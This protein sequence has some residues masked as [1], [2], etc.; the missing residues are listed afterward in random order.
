MFVTD[1]HGGRLIVLSLDDDLKVVA[2]HKV[3]L[4]W[5]VAV[6]LGESVLAIGHMGIGCMDMRAASPKDW[7][8]GAGHPSG[9]VADLVY[10]GDRLF[11]VDC[12]KQCL[13][14]FAVALSAAAA[15]GPITTAGAAL[16][17]LTPI[18]TVDS[19]SVGAVCLYGV[20]AAPDGVSVFVGDRS[21]S[22]APLQIDG[23]G[24][25][26]RRLPTATAVGKIWSLC[27]AHNKLFVLTESG[28][29]AL[30]TAMDLQT[31]TLIGPVATAAAD[32]PTAIFAAEDC[33]IFVETEHTIT[34][35]TLPDSLVATTATTATAVTAV[36]ARPH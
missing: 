19:D 20:A 11:A 9:D 27:V 24:R 12:E 3:R 25:V 34:I 30:V 22:C 15:T 4:P 8:M 7:Q 1:Y 36:D 29:R 23:T 17:D 33:L 32:N 26:V 35:W 18:A 5:G 28:G 21:Q 14:I 6:C 13:Y 2:S 10:A 31:D 16:I